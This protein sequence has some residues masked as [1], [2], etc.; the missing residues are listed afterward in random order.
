[1]SRPLLSPAELAFWHAFELAHQRVMGGVEAQL[2]G[3]AKLSGQDFAVL[4]RL[5]DLGAGTLRQQ[6]LADAMHWEKSRLSH[7]LSR[8]AARGLIERKRESAKSVTVRLTRSGRTALASARSAHATAV[9]THLLDA[10]PARERAVLER[11]YTQLSR[12]STRSG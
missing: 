2:Q 1:M 4:S 11:V 10:V 5:E 7:Q 9:R 6:R 8:M 3:R 12:A